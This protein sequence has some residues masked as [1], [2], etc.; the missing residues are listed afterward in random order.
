MWSS[1]SK[2]FLRATKNTPSGFL[3]GKPPSF[4]KKAESVAHVLVGCS[5][6]AQTKYI[7]RHNAASKI[8]F[9]ELLREHGSIEEVPP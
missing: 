7:Y 4:R 1:V 3:K 9:F 2:K 6:L 5:S 8:L